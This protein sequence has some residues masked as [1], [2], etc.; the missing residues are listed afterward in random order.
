[1]LKCKCC[2]LIDSHN[3][4]LYCLWLFPLLML[5]AVMAIT[6]THA[7]TCT[8]THTHAHT[9]LV[10]GCV[11]CVQY[12]QITEVDFVANLERDL[13]SPHQP[14]LLPFLKVCLVTNG[15]G[16]AV[17]CA[18]SVTDFRPPTPCSPQDSVPYLRLFLYHQQQF[19]KRYLAILQ[20][21]KKQQVSTTP[22]PTTT[23]TPTQPQTAPSSVGVASLPSAGVK[24][25]VSELQ[26]QA[27]AL[28]RLPPEQRQALL[29]QHPQLLSPQLKQVLFQLQQQQQQKGS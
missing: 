27:L 26:K 24:T 12:N 15:T 29:Q 17:S 20:Q 13:N 22:T 11:F 25:P 23:A 8:H 9:L 6:H 3:I 18:E 28:S 21:K 10:H 7:H 14:N 19:I 2:V 4:P 5:S 16:S 1:M